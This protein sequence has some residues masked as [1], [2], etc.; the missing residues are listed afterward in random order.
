MK[1]YDIKLGN[2]TI[3]DYFAKHEAVVAEIREIG[4][5]ISESDRS[6]AI[7]KGLPSVYDTLIDSIANNKDEVPLAE[8]KNQISSKEARINARKTD[9]SEKVLLASQPKPNGTETSSR[10]RFRSGSRRGFRRGFRSGFRGRGGSSYF[11]G[12]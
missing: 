5:D 2:D 3:V 10:N 9:T 1:L 4:G 7:L 6:A 11:R 12:R 8:V